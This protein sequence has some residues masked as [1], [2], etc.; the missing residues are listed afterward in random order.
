MGFS[1]Q[2]SIA[3]TVDGI[4]ITEDEV[5]SYIEGFRQ[6]KTER[7]TASGWAS[8][9][10]NNG[11]TAESLRE[12]VLNNVFIPKAVIRIQAK[13]LSLEVTEDELDQ[14]IQK[15]K[16][17]YEERTGIGSWDSV[18]ASYGYDEDKWRDNEQDRLLEERLKETVIPDFTPTSSQYKS[19]GAKIASTYNSKHS[20]FIAFDSQEYAEEALTDLGGTDVQVTL[21]KFKK[22]G[23]YYA[24][25][26]KAD[27]K[28]NALNAQASEEA[29][30][31]A[32]EQ[33]DAEQEENAEQNSA[34]TSVQTSTQVGD[35]PSYTQVDGA[36][37]AGWAALSNSIGSKN[38]KYTNALNEL[39]VGKVSEVIDMENGEYVIIF[40]DESFLASAKKEAINLDKIPKEIAK[41]VK[42]DVKQE[43]MDKKFEDWLEKATESSTVV[44]NAMP[45]NV[46]YKDNQSS[47]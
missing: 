10:S 23:S 4:S 11:F 46:S 26:A 2:S 7:E 19:Y 34:S 37:N 25:L 40:C 16:S 27:A 21:N 13:N 44:I 15:E 30:K 39:E 12:Y 22:S 36:V 33:S 28:M 18:L 35:T 9:L 1:K 31:A 45:S 14:T 41:Q 6:E 32:T 5:T 24:K 47:R 29:T 42:K 3:A 8:W 17:Y 20:Y 43:L 38:K